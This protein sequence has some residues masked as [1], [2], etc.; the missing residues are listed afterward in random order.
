[1]T[2]SARRRL[3]VGLTL[4]VVLLVLRFAHLLTTGQAV[5]IGLVGEAAEWLVLLGG[6]RAGVLLYRKKRA[7]GAE[8]L[9]A[10]EVAY[11]SQAGV[12]VTRF[13]MA[14]FR[15]VIPFW[16]WVLRRPP[17]KPSMHP[18]SYH[19]PVR[20]RMWLAIASS[21]I[22]MMAAQAYFLAAYDGWL[23]WLPVIVGRLV[24][25]WLLI[26]HAGWLRRPHLVDSSSIELHRGAL[27][28]V[29]IARADVLK[30]VGERRLK[31]RCGGWREVASGE[32]ELTVA[33]STNVALNLLPDAKVTL[34]GQEVAATVIRLH[35]D[36]PEAFLR[37]LDLAARVDVNPRDARPADV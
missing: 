11:E 24:P 8:G 10:L 34:C 32:F 23:A 21:V 37:G 27:T 14:V 17:R 5:V 4:G 36:D 22:A 6:V 28:E 1:M 12:R 16:E 26:L 33:G 13:V 9:E 19:G 35:V 2:R 25:L 20:T 31:A 3:L 29:T 18:F 7:S 15:L 30:A